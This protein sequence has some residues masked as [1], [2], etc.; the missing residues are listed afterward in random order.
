MFRRA[1]KK[2][3]IAKPESHDKVLFDS[4]ST[5]AHQLKSINMKLRDVLEDS[6]YSD[7]NFKIDENINPKALAAACA[8]LVTRNAQLSDLCM[9][10][11]QREDPK[12]KNEQ[13]DRRV[14]KVLFSFRKA[15][16]SLKE[17]KNTSDNMNGNLSQR[18]INKVMDNFYDD[19]SGFENEL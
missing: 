11:L 8:Q 6:T 18:G 14:E 3:V 9:N 2:D 1:A 17:L 13:F 16:D 15:K 19:A 12:R 5:V 10:Q 4:L 7:F